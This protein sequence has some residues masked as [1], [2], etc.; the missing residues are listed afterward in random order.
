MYRN[1][2]E[3]LAR[4]ALLAVLLAAGIA[5]AACGG[6]S[7]S[8]GDDDTAETDNGQVGD[9]G[10]N[11]AEET[12][13]VGLEGARTLIASRLTDPEEEVTAEVAFS[14]L[15]E[16]TCDVR[17]ED[18]QGRLVCVRYDEN[19]HDASP[20]ASAEPVIQYVLDIPAGPEDAINA[21]M[22]GLPGSEFAPVVVVS[23]DL[24]IDFGTHF[25]GHA[26]S[27]QGEI[28]V[29]DPDPAN[30]TAQ[31][32]MVNGPDRVELSLD[33]D[34]NGCFTLPPSATALSIG[35]HSVENFTVASTS[36]Q[37]TDLGSVQESI[38][39][40]VVEQAAA[41]LQVTSATVQ[42][43][44]TIL[45]DEPIAGHLSTVSAVVANAGGTADT[46]E[47][48]FHVDDD[49]LDTQEVTVLADDTATVQFP[50][51][52]AAEGTYE[53]ALNDL[54]MGVEVLRPLELLDASLKGDM[55]YY[56]DGTVEVE[57]EFE[58]ANRT[59]DSE[60]L[61]LRLEGF[62]FF[63]GQ[64]MWI[65]V[66]EWVESLQPGTHTLDRSIDWDV[67]SSAEIPLRLLAEDGTEVELGELEIQPLEVISVHV[68]PTSATQGSELMIEWGVGNR[69]FAIP[70][71]HEKEMVI[72]YR[73]RLTS[74]ASWGGWQT[75][76]TIQHSQAGS[77][78]VE[79]ATFTPGTIGQYEF[80]VNDRISDD[81]VTIT[82]DSPTI[83][84][85]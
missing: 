50:W 71:E 7:S 70:T 41:D 76:D 57:V 40:F 61:A 3:P 23:D 37:R 80:R 43:G 66:E 45:G 55:D 29:V 52:P 15:E 38:G 53:L 1:Q 46:L 6:G 78:S 48:E 34:G 5:L 68:E 77:T 35:T 26:F 21:A 67:G 83:P 12:Q 28:C 42:P 44:A 47:V 58:L 73:Y 16:I 2:H 81:V 17:G 27:P 69:F 49:L 75:I 84:G 20:T 33:N 79:T 54:E 19:T 74:G 8:S 59:T 39:T 31:V 22:D 65:E 56:P 51:T 24:D 10:D 30:L 13:P 18:A 62:T 4:S 9:P 63:S 11:G 25:P 14:P 82:L 64:P 60:S 85:L 72:Q 32:E 36:G